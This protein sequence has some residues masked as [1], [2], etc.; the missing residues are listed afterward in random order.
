MT[1]QTKPG[2]AIDARVNEL[3]NR[4]PLDEKLAQL[5]GVWV[6]DLINPQRA[7][8][9]D[10]AKPH[11][12]HDLEDLQVRAGFDCEEVGAGMARKEELLHLLDGLANASLIV[13]VKPRTQR[14][15]FLHGRSIT[16]EHRWVKRVVDPHQLREELLLEAF[17][18]WH[19]NTSV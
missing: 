11:L 18:H 4:M 8:N 14:F 12:Q 10:K 19:S 5:G 3:L 6:T 2:E 7:F 16:P 17:F 15:E 13:D 1:V 9:P